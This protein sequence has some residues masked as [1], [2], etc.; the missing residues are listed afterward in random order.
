MIG[1][2]EIMEAILYVGFSYAIGMLIGML[3][4]GM[5]IVYGFLSKTKKLLQRDS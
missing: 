5:L 1:N 4:V 2:K 3:I